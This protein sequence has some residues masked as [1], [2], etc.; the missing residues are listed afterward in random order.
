MKIK[1]FEEKAL[2]GTKVRYRRQVHTITDRNLRTHEAILDKF[3]HVRCS[4]IELAEEPAKKKPGKVF[5]KVG[6]I[7]RFGKVRLRVEPLPPERCEACYFYAYCT[8]GM[9]P[10][11]PHIDALVCTS[12][13]REDGRVVVFRLVNP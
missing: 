12:G 9:Q 7:L 1:D 10:S 2:I 13:Q 5:H 11:D 6:A 4:E 3:R 8:N